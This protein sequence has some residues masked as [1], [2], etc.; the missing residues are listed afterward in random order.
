MTFNPTF[1]HYINIASASFIQPSSSLGAVQTQI[2]RNNLEWQYHFMNSQTRI[3]YLRDSSSG[4][5][6]MVSIS[7]SNMPQLLKTFGPFRMN[8]DKNGQPMPVVVL[9]NQNLSGNV[10]TDAKYTAVLRLVDSNGY[11]SEVQVGTFITSSVQNALTNNSPRWKTFNTP[12]SQYITGSMT[13]SSSVVS[14]QFYTV[15][16]YQFKSRAVKIF[17]PTPN[18]INNQQGAIGY[19]DILVEV[20]NSQNQIVSYIY[21]LYAREVDEAYL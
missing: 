5:T 2:I 14:T 6:Y 16:P 4:N 20:T 15:K 12:Y 19:V 21:G 11:T 9:L 3:N 18:Y 13:V 1:P 10:S 17:D 7:G 8:L